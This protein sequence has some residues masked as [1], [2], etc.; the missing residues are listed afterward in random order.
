[1]KKLYI[2]LSGSALL[3]SSCGSVKN[4][5][6]LSDLNG[7]WNIVEIDGTPLTTKA[8]GRQ[9]FIG[10][11]TNSGKIY[12]NSGC[13]SMT[14]SLD[15]ASAPGKIDFGK[16]ASTMMACPDM[17]NEQ[18]VLGAL[19]KV[20]QYRKDG[21]NMIV[22]YDSSDNTTIT[23]KKRFEVMPYSELQGKWMITSVFNNP[24]P[25]E[26]ENHPYL[27]FDTENNRVHG[28]LACNNFNASIVRPEG[29]ASA[30]SIT[31][32]ATTR[33]MCPD[34]ETES[35]ILSA[36]NNI[37]TFGRIDKNTIAFFSADGEQLL[38]LTKSAE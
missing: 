32:G 9:A 35:S 4:S 23:L 20:D 2:G 24:I 7:E 16:M 10:F 14:S 15:L 36:I 22:L 30:I 17:E 38:T 25:S 5:A 31:Q 6:T 26:I 8:G 37:K 12:G 18:K 28:Q 34:M 11:D 21:D 13:N 27:A 33:M 19:A 29:N 1:M 3:L